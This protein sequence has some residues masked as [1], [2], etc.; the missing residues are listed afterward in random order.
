MQRFNSSC[1]VYT[2]GTQENAHYTWGKWQ[3]LKPTYS[4]ELEQ[5]LHA[6]PRENGRLRNI[7]WKKYM[8]DHPWKELRED[9]NTP[10]N[11]MPQVGGMSRP[12]GFWHRKQIVS[13]SPTCGMV[14]CHNPLHSPGSTPHPLLLHN[15]M[16]EFPKVNKVWS[17]FPCVEKCISSEFLGLPIIFMLGRQLDWCQELINPLLATAGV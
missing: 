7:I 4:S 16:S 3:D 1:T 6:L 14:G 8:W 12:W 5:H 15:L 2:C 13:E 17:E 10:V 9:Y 11:V